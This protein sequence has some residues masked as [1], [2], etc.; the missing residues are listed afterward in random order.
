MQVEMSVSASRSFQKLPEAGRKDQKL[1][2][3]TDTA[4]VCV[5]TVQVL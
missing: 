5:W 1:F 4:T 3:R 2:A